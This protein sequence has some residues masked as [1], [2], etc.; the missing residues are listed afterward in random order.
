MIKQHPSFNIPD[1]M[2]APLWRYLSIEKLQSLLD[3]KALYF[4]RAD[5]L[6]DDHEGSATK[7]AV[8]N[9]PIFY[10]GATK[11]FIEEGVVEMAKQWAR[12][13]YIN[14]WHVNSG[15]SIA[16]WKLYTK[17]GKGIAIQSKISLLKIG[18][19]ETDK[20]FC[21]GPVNYADYERDHMSEANA[22]IPFFY[23]RNI[24]EYEREFR[25][26]T[27]NL[28]DIGAVVRGTKEPEKGFF[29]PINLDVLIQRIVVSPYAKEITSKRVE[30]LLKTHKLL[31]KYSKST[32]S[33]IPTF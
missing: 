12:C 4:S 20:Q 10:S 18:I 33:R 19:L 2:D 15:E 5:L 16:M 24:Y 22:F 30:D 23:K 14:C 8:D 13:T 21:L 28:E 3:K 1:N 6:G 9:R 31:S 11:H 32:V 17:E 25:I 29:I 7:P 27:D 26:L